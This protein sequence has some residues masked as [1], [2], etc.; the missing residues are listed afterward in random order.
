MKN[1]SVRLAVASVVAVLSVLGLSQVPGGR[2]AA[3]TTAHADRAAAGAA[4]H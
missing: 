3:R 1:K 2:R 4:S